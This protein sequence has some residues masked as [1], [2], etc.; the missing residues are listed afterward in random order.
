[1]I[2]RGFQDKTV[3]FKYLQQGWTVWHQGDDRQTSPTALLWD[4][5]LRSER[6]RFKIQLQ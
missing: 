2:E 3:F 4:G 5:G 1:M 6:E